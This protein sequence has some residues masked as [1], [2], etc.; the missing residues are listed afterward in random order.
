MNGMGIKWFV[1]IVLGLLLLVVL[2]ML[3]ILWLLGG[4]ESGVIG[5][6]FVCLLLWVVIIS[7]SVLFLISVGVWVVLVVV[8]VVLFGVFWLLCLMV[9]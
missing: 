1:G 5:V 8:N 4:W 3:V 2:C 7:V 9:I 6:L